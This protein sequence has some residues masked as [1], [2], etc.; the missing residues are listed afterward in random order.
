M[1]V[2]IAGKVS[3][4]PV[5]ETFIKFA[6]AEMWL[7]EKGHETVN[8]LRLCSSKWT[9]EQCMRVC[10]PE[11]MKCDAICLLHDW[12]ESRGAVWEYHDAQMLKMPVM[13]FIPR[14]G[15]LSNA[16]CRDVA[17]NVST[18]DKTERQ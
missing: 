14:N 7:R 17:R 3:G 16:V 13:V 12:A 4:L 18:A 5:G 2:Y 6:Q 9:W 11:L 15:I 10:I 8:P 1:K